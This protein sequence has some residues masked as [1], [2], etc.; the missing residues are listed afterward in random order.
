MTVKEAMAYLKVS[1][2]TLYALMARG[3]LRWVELPGVRGRRFRREDL[4]ALQ[5]EGRSKG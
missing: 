5:R 4:D 1:R 3:Q 2:V